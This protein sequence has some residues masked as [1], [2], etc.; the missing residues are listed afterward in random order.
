ML[1]DRS[2]MRRPAPAIQW[3][4]TIALLVLNLAVY[5]IQIS[6]SQ[7]P[8]NEYFALSKDGLLHGYVWQLLTFQF[9]HGGHFHLIFNLLALYMFGRPVEER[10][11]K[12]AF[13]K[14]YLISGMIGGLFQAGLG[15][16]LPMQFGLPVLGASAGLCGLVAAFALL[17]PEATI[18]LFFIIP[19]RAK[20]VL[21]LAVILTLTFLILSFKP[22][23]AQAGEKVAHAA[24]LGGLL[25]GIAYLRWGSY[26]ESMFLARR[27]RRTMIRP[28]E[29]IRVH[30]P[31]AA[32][33]QQ[34]KAGEAEEL[35]PAE[36][37]SREVDPIL[38][39]ISA[40]GIHSLTPRE[41]RILEAARAKIRKR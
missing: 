20:Y 40:H 39:K 3:S 9:L 32:P 2:Y 1:D 36:F 37:I 35:P 5:L 14:L 10:L 38:D 17:E 4:P 30:S 33:W 28:R 6:S 41:R 27:P 21:G 34:P 29:L 22:E 25:A 24:H 11:G 31:K 8:I 18:L 15:F 23:S 12:A 7:F 26:V 19:M 13:L 16:I